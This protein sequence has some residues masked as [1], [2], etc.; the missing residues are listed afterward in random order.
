MQKQIFVCYLPGLDLRHVT[1]ENTPNLVGL[2]DSFPSA[3][4]KSYPCS[5]LLPAILT[6]TYPCDHG[7]YQISLKKEHK[8][9]KRL[10]DYFPDALTT[11]L[12]CFFSLFNRKI[13]LPGIPPRRRRTLDLKTRFKFYLRSSSSNV[14]MNING[15]ETIFS[16]IGAGPGQSSY[17][18]TMEFNKLDNMLSSICQG[19]HLFEFLEIH[20][21]DI[22][23]LWHTGQQDKISA[24]YRHI[25][26]F[27][28]KLK[29]QCDDT[30]TTLVILSDRA[31]EPITESINIK[32]FLKTFLSQ[33]LTTAILSSH[34]WR[35]SGSGTTGLE[36]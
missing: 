10:I 26:D 3:T 20:S 8:V 36:N 23:Q 22:V 11:S 28:F 34:Q 16:V 21:L 24:A 33:T 29:K 18:F 27:L 32:K 25:D 17:K 4:L 12:Q 30:D 9:D 35:D 14:L 15:L 31:V 1:P 7:K 5:E 6:G 19:K 13:D 2:I